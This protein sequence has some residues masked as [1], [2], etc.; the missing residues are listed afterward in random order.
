VVAESVAADGCFVGVAAGVGEAEDALPGGVVGEVEVHVGGDD[1]G[2]HDA[3]AF[4]AE[5][6]AG[7]AEFVHEAG[8]GCLVVAAVAG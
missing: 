2:A 8:A 7:A 3:D 5:A 4:G 6:G 1:A